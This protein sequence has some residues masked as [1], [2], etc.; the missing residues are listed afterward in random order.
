MQLSKAGEYA[1]RS[2]IHLAATFGKGAIPFADISKTWSI[3][4]SFLRKILNRLVQARLVHSARGTGGG[5]TLAKE[6]QAITI[7][8]IVE[9][10]EGRIYLNQ[11][12][13]G[14]EWCENRAWCPVHTVWRQAQN[15]FAEVLRASTLAD[16]VTN[17]EFKTHFKI[18]HE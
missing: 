5:Y 6:P 2:M 14:P 4:P 10:I 11:C 7:L 13:I 8:D 3:P 16:M 9:A 1:V 15:A 12:L 18:I 17:R